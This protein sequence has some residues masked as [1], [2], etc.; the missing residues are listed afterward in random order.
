[1]NTRLRR[2]DKAR[3]PLSLLVLMLVIVIVIDQAKVDR[4][5]KIEHEHD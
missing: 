5:E 1:M 3:S 2:V 4:G